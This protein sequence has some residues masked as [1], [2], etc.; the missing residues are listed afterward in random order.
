MSYKDFVRKQGDKFVA[1]SSAEGACTASANTRIQAIHKW[2]HYTTADLFKY[3]KQEITL[4][5]LAERMGV[6]PAE[7]LEYADTEARELTATESLLP[8]G[9]TITY[10]TKPT[11]LPSN[12]SYLVKFPELP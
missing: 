1:G 2:L 11:D 9:A 12:V 6:P 3:W 5:Q 4:E 8:P 7:A 10:L